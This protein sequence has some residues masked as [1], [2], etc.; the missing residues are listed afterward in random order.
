VPCVCS[1]LPVQ[2]ENSAGGGCLTA[3]VGDRAGWKS[4]LR[5]ILTDDALQRR[6]A[7]EAAA[8]PLPTWADA[9]RRLREALTGA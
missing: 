2:R 8:R 6:L 4:A 3:A 1:D 7:A 9:A 5:T